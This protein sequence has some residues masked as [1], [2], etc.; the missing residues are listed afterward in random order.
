MFIGGVR[1]AVVEFKTGREQITAGMNGFPFRC[2]LRCQPP[3]I[4]IAILGP[5]N[6]ALLGKCC[7]PARPTSGIP[8]GARAATARGEFRPGQE[9]KLQ[10]AIVQFIRV[11]RLNPRLVAHLL[12]CGHGNDSQPARI[13][14]IIR[15]IANGPGPAIFRVTVIEK[16]IGARVDD[17]PGQR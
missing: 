15:M 3:G 6:P 12:R 4:A 2:P 10:Q 8:A 17:L 1:P 13:G 5:A 16:G 9:T 7:K 11:S 14:K